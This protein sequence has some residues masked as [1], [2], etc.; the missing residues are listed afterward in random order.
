MIQIG[1]PQDYPAAGCLSSLLAHT[2]GLHTASMHKPK[3]P[4]KPSVRLK[5]RVGDF[6]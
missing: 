2:D 3:T 1:E 4:V 6:A 5:M